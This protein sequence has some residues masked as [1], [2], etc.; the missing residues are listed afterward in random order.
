MGVIQVVFDLH[1]GGILR[2]VGHVVLQEDG[3]ETA[4]TPTGPGRLGDQLGGIGPV[5][6]T[7][8]TGLIDFQPPLGPRHPVLGCQPQGD[9]QPNQPQY[10]A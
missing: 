2:L 6:G 8:A 5:D 7:H 3:L 10:P 4:I 9:A 1:H